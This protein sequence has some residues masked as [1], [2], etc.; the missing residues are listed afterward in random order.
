[1]RMSHYIA[2][3][4]STTPD[5]HNENAKAD[6]GEVKMLGQE[7]VEVLYTMRSRVYHFNKE[8]NAWE[9]RGVGNFRIEEFV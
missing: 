6:D 8:T 3:M 5:S 2:K 4:V 1:M 7:G 9:S